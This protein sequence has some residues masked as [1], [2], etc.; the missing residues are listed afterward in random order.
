MALGE[1]DNS[2][3]ETW[4]RMLQ[5]LKT[6]AKADDLARNRASKQV[7]SFDFYCFLL[8]SIAAKCSE[9]EPIRGLR[10]PGAFLEASRCFWEAKPASPMA[11]SP[12]ASV[13]GAQIT[14]LGPQ[15]WLRHLG[16]EHQVTQKHEQVKGRSWPASF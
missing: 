6:D 14:C 10:L 11:P 8:I 13:G 3:W 2:P 12:S 16:A 1:R 4:R 7:G 9:V 5:S 15:M